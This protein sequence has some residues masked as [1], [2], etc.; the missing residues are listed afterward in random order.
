MKDIDFIPEWYKATRKRRKRYHRQ[1]VILATMLALMMG[2]SFVVGR[3]VKTVKAD[4]SQIQ[5]VI[6]RSRK[7]IDEG[8]KLEAEI[9][10]LKQ[11]T[12]IMEIAE[13]R[14]DISTVVAELSA[15]VGDNIILSRLLLKDE[16]IK[17][18][19]ESAVATAIVKIGAAAE[20]KDGF[21]IQTR[22]R[23]TLTGIAAAPADA[24]RL[25]S[26]LEQSEYFCQET[27]VYSRPK[28]VKKHDVTEFEICCYVADYHIQ[29]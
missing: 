19:K 6:D 14:T 23:V 2:W 29:K 17:E 18:L 15:L 13:P 24:A 8:S 12:G 3:Q 16:T 28:T 1:Y 11:Q 21:L 5:N 25:I 4:V 9:A 26:Q 7:M 22:R 10:L 20:K 27:L